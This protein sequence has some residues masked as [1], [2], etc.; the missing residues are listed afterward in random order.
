MINDLKLSFKMLKYGHGM[1]MTI[2]GCVVFALF[3][4]LMWALTFMGDIGFSG[5]YFFSLSGV[6]VQQLLSSTEYANFVQA[7]PAKRRLQTSGCTML[8]MV[9]MVASYLIGTLLELILILVKPQMIDAACERQIFLMLM[10]A[11]ITIYGSVCYKLYAVATTVFFIS[12]GILFGAMQG[13]F[14]SIVIVG[15]IGKFGV[16]SAVGVVVIVIA[17]G[18][19][20]LLTLAVYKIPMSKYAQGAALRRQL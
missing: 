16:I 5:G 4:V 20:Y 8:T 13:Y 1:K 3:A 11:L 6:F 7:S 10:M 15:S 19:G 2:V 12:F 17:C 18:L 14:E 9:F